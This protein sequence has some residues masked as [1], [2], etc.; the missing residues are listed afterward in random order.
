MAALPGDL[1]ARARGAL[2]AGCDVVLHCNGDGAEMS[3]VARSSGPLSAAARR[4]LD[5]GEA[6][7]RKR[8]EP[9]E[10]RPAMLRFAA[11][12]AGEG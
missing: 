7:R 5:A 12:M 11:L 9:L 1:G 6:L 2:A 10:R 8:A 3:A 4:R